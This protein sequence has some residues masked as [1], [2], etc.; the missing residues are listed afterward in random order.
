MKI[1]DSVGVITGGASGL[2]ERVARMLAENGGRAAIWDLPDSKGPQLAS[3]FDGNVRFV[4][5]D[6]TNPDQVEAAAA[7]SMEAFGRIDLNVNAAGIS[8]AHRVIN[9][10][11]E[12]HPLDTFK[13][14][15]EVNLVGLFDVMRHCALE[16]SRNEPG[17]DGE[18]GLIVNVTSIAAF[19]GQPGQAAYTA[20]KAGV[21]AL[22]L[23]LARDLERQA[24]RVM[25]VAPGM[26]DTAMLAGVGEERRQALTDIHLFP[27][28]LGRAEEFAQLVRSMM[29]IPLLNGEVIRL[30]AATRLG[31]DKR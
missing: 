15:V 20:S 23:Q 24:I 31:M 9:R 8:P 29:E 6:V 21:A 7:A 25:G 17:E 12:M 26:M 18:R 1:R 22:T 10:Q 16:M 5:T 4:P 2:G 13:K 14:V 11:G 19:E 30:D 3:E 28:R 27:K